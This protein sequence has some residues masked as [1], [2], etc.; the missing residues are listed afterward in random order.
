[1]AQNV[2]RPIFVKIINTYVEKNVR[3]YEIF[4][5]LPRP[6]GV[7]GGVGVGVAS[8]LDWFLSLWEKF[9]HS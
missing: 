9:T 4:K 7:V 3:K 2:S 1:M 6:G 8:F 5:K